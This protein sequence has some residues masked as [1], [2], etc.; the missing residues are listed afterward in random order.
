MRSTVRVLTLAA[1]LAGVS[2]I[3][4]GYYHWVF[5]VN[6]KGPYEPIRERFDL[7][8]LPGG[9]VSY[10]ISNQGP[11]PMVAGDNFTALVSQIR[12]AAD[13]WNGVATS[14]LR[15]QFGGVT[16]IGREQKAP[17]IDVVF[18]D[19]MPP[20]IL[21]QSWPVTYT[22][23][24]FLGEA[25]SPGFAPILRSRMHL[26]KDLTAY[27][28]ASYSDRF[29]LTIVHE[30]GHTLGLQHSLTSAVMST[31]ITRATSKPQPL[32]A[33]DIAGLSLL[34]PTPEFVATTGS[35]AGRIV[36]EDHGGAN[37]V[38]VV[39]VSADGTTI[40]TM[41]NPDGTYMIEGLPP[42]DYYV[43][44]HP[45]PPAQQG[46]GLPAAIIPPTDLDGNQF[47]A[48]T[49]VETLFYPG[50][51]KWA[52]AEP[53]HVDAGDTAEQIS[54]SL[55]PRPQGP[56]IYN[57]QTYSYLGPDGGVPV[58]APPLVSGDRLY[59]AFG[60]PGTAV[61]GAAQLA[62]GLN[63]SVI[64][65]PAQLEPDTLTYWQQGFGL[66][67]ADALEVD[68]ATRVAVAV[69]TDTD[70]YVLP[71]AFSVLPSPHPQI[72][73]VD[74]STD[75]RGAAL[76][77]ITG[78][79]LAAATKLLFD[80]VPGKIV[81][82]NEDGSL[83][84]SAPPATGNHQAVVEA[85]T[86]GGQTS[87]QLL[88][89]DQA[90]P[91]FTYAAP[92]VTISTV[93]PGQLVAGTDAMLQIDA[94][95]TSFVDG[96]TVIGFGSS[97]IV[98]RQ[99]WVV[100]PTR[101]RLNVSVGPGTVRGP[102]ELTVLNGLQLVTNSVLQVQDGGIVSLRTPILNRATGLAGVPAGGSV[103]IQTAGLPQ[104]LGGWTLSIGGQRTSFVAGAYGQLTA[105]VP[106]GVQTGLAEVRLS[107]PTG[108]TVQ[109][110]L[111]QIDDQ[112]PG[113][114]KALAPDGA[115]ISLGHAVGAGDEVTLIVGGLADPGV[116]LAPEGVQVRAGGV[117][118]KLASVR[119]METPG[120]WE[121]VFVLT[122]TG[123][124]AEQSV[125]V[126]I[127][128]RVSAPWAVAIKPAE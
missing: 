65:G 97:D 104:D 59:L 73:S 118:E 34:Y 109:P 43:Y 50:T 93:Q 20:G 94:V 87:W 45:L 1:L 40:G 98:V 5:F 10:F 36:A 57:V 124:G 67:V 101:L 26:R 42:G 91:V 49:Q 19:E 47:L 39:A 81:Q 37:L 116:M 16:E 51:R 80:G 120:L 17:G 86:A 12:A 25:N 69:T 119:A 68:Q 123:S 110:V 108:A 13:A 2:S 113:I 126:G 78:T 7:N 4:S 27:S 66:I 71:G 11:D 103:I 55:A 114:L 21:A 76:A 75:V 14:A 44:A 111:L 122:N 84:V 29:F 23:V 64:G 63:L 24:H 74:S 77:T 3:A 53:V 95:N 32:S 38:S 82:A 79:N 107:S 46:E 102:V 41:T 28:Q 115:D 89:S 100:S 92:D 60:G 121:V 15:L 72:S 9:V 96:Q 128:T 127:G 70:L 30:F 105:E 22:D 35:I 99:L 33:D 54:I 88:G 18:D 125:T 6:G 56:A 85:M 90:P 58:H 31:E 62:P 52:E 106:A 48:Y 8:A 117:I 61:A 112:P 83:T